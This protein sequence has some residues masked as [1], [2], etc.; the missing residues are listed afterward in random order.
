MLVRWLLIVGTFWLPGLFN[1][2]SRADFEA[3]VCRRGCVES[4]VNQSSA[5]CGY[6][7]TWLHVASVHCRGRL[8][9]L[10]AQ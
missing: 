2:K 7:S 3:G 6:V 1:F 4:F 5:C 10:R 9:N 8:N